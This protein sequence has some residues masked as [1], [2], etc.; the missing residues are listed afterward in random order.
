MSAA[1]TNH[2]M[3]VQCNPN[4]QVKNAGIKVHDMEYDDG[5]APPEEVIFKWLKV[6]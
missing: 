4:E 1:A 3:L 5:S 6:C 2:T